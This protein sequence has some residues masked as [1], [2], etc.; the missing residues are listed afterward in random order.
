MGQLHRNQDHYTWRLTQRLCIL[1]CVPNDIIILFGSH[2]RMFGFSAKASLPWLFSQGNLPLPRRAIATRNQPTRNQ[3]TRNQGNEEPSPPGTLKAT[4]NPNLTTATEPKEPLSFP[5]T[6]TL[7]YFQSLKPTEMRPHA[8]VGVACS[9]AFALTEPVC[10][11]PGSSWNY[12]RRKLDSSL[13]RIAY[14]NDRCRGRK[15]YTSRLFLKKNCEANI[16]KR[17]WGIGE[18]N[19][20][21]AAKHTRN[22]L[23][24]LRARV[25]KD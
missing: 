25:L 8:N 17:Q 11:N 21:P 9:Q 3:P 19:S 15:D 5:I 6:R 13:L 23:T 18:S 12:C 10:T 20:E 2:P 4:R 1:E 24:G 14:W 22:K 16:G 7:L